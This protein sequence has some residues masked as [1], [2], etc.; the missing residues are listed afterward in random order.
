[1]GNIIRKSG[2]CLSRISESVCVRDQSSLHSNQECL[3]LS[4]FPKVK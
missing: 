4:L 1:M 3:D 2:T